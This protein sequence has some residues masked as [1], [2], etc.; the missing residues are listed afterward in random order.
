MTWQIEQRHDGRYSPFAM[1][2]ESAANG[3]EVVP[4]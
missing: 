4:G 2:P 3:G 1:L